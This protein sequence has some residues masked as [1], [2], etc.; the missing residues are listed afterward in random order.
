MGL[1]STQNPKYG[2]LL[3]AEIC[4]NF[5]G[6]KGTQSSKAEGLGQHALGHLVGV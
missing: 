4:L 1:L 2:V 5:K 6:S 3:K